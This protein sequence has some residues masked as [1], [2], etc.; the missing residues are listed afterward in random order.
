MSFISDCF[1]KKVSSDA[2]NEGNNIERLSL[3]DFVLTL[4]N[5]R[6]L[7]GF[8][9]ALIKFREDARFPRVIL[10]ARLCGVG[11]Y[12]NLYKERTNPN[13]EHG[14]AKQ[15]VESMGSRRALS[16]DFDFEIH[17]GSYSAKPKR[18]SVIITTPTTKVDHGSAFYYTPN[19]CDVCLELLQHVFPGADLK[20]SLD[21][22][23]TQLFITATMAVKALHDMFKKSSQWNFAELRGICRELKVDPPWAEGKRKALYG[24]VDTIKGK[25]NDMLIEDTVNVDKFMKE[26]IDL[27]ITEASDLYDAVDRALADEEAKRLEEVEL[28]R[29][30]G[31]QI[32]PDSLDPL[33]S[34]E[35]DSVMK[36]IHLMGGPYAQTWWMSDKEL[37][38]DQEAKA[39]EAEKARL[40]T[41]KTIPGKFLKGTSSKELRLK[42]PDL[43]WKLIFGD[44][45]FH[46]STQRSPEEMQIRLRKII[47]EIIKTDEKILNWEAW[48]WDP[49]WDWGGLCLV[50]ESKEEKPGGKGHENDGVDEVRE[51]SDSRGDSGF[52]GN[53]DD[54]KL[55]TNDFLL[56][57]K[58]VQ[59][60]IRT[61]KLSRKGSYTRS[62]T[63]DEILAL[64]I[65]GS[66]TVKK[67]RDSGKNSML[68][69]SLSIDTAELD[70]TMTP[71][72]PKRLEPL[73]PSPIKSRLF[74]PTRMKPD[75]DRAND[76][77]CQKH[78][79]GRLTL[80]SS[81]GELLNL[82]GGSADIH[83]GNKLELTH[84][85]INDRAAQKLAKYLGDRSKPSLVET[86][87]LRDNTI[88]A[89]GCEALVTALL[90]EEKT[91]FTSNLTRLDLSQNRIGLRGAQALSAL[92]SSKGC[93]LKELNINGNKL[94]DRAVACVTRSM[95]ANQS[96]C[97]L[98]MSH[99][100]LADPRFFIGRM[101]EANN[102]LE[103]LGMYPQIDVCSSYLLSVLTYYCG[104]LLKT[105]DGTSCVV[106][107]L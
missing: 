66:M 30:R 31:L 22:P 56:H 74:E 62:L 33:P 58:G 61:L 50:N 40:E 54:A 17:V 104:G 98:G 51:E 35:H 99:N 19:A 39:R 14:G 94:G 71:S 34:Q 87:V 5:R 9:Q 8:I 78:G 88:H 102:A 41:S 29:I 43:D 26:A 4:V 100:E 72:T 73:P 46:I 23:P 53:A 68:H 15:E 107:L 82:K 65:K 76:D 93:R 12:M 67:N 84:L 101:L 97:T 45:R 59:K 105:S 21:C 64:D 85:D 47:E 89:E 20:D 83:D 91:V 13:S 3:P 42:V 49:D 86:V 37:A 1:E 55:E 16:G 52:D 6:E 44:T 10:F 18:A 36:L 103:K 77:L 57:R 90:N 24:M 79:K 75:I 28:E 69:C 48:E 80:S 106:K 38:A 60:E 32:D 63:D 92:I 11:W 2:V 96:I 95:A 70:S 27:W 7:P 25:K 81:T